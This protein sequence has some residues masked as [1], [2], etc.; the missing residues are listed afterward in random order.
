MAHRLEQADEDMLRA[1]RRGADFGVH[2]VVRVPA[3]RQTD[4]EPAWGRVLRAWPSLTARVVPVDGGHAVYAA[5]APD[6]SALA[7]TEP[8]DSRTILAAD[9]GWLARHRVLPGQGLELLLHHLVVDADSLAAVLADLDAVLAGDAPIGSPDWP[10]AAAAWTPD[11]PRSSEPGRSA[12]VGRA[13]AGSAALP[14]KRR[15]APGTHTRRMLDPTVV[16]RIATAARTAGVTPFAIHWA[17]ASR[18]AAQSD[19]VEAPLAAVVSRRLLTAVPSRA[20]NATAYLAV[21][22][23]P[24]GPGRDGV[25]A[26]FDAFLSVWRGHRPTASPNRSR[27]LVSSANT[28]AAQSYRVIDEVLLG[29]YVVKYPRHLQV[30][31]LDPAGTQVLLEAYAAGGGE[32]LLGQHLRALAELLDELVPIHETQQPDCPTIESPNRLPRNQFPESDTLPTD[33]AVEV[34]T[35]GSTPT[36][37]ASAGVEARGP[38]ERIL[39]ADP[40]TALRDLDIS[41]FDVLD[42]LDGLDRRGVRVGVDSFYSWERVADVLTLLAESVASTPGPVERQSRSA[43]AGDGSVTLAHLSDI[44]IDA[45]RHDEPERYAVGYAY[46]VDPALGLDR[47]DV[48][49][50]CQRVLDRHPALGARLGFDRRGV[51][52]IPGVTRVVVRTV[53]APGLAALRDPQPLS[54]RAPAHLADLAV[55]TVDPVPGDRAP[56]VVALTLHHLLVDHVGL[57]ALVD[58]LARELRG[59]PAW[60]SADWAELAEPLAEARLRALKVW[61][62]DPLPTDLG[63]VGRGGLTP[64]HY[65][66]HRLDWG[67]SD[68]RLVLAEELTRV[69]AAIAEWT[70]QPRGLI[71]SV[72]HGRA[73]PGSDRLVGAL[74]RVLPVAYD[75]AEPA[76]L[77]ASAR[78]VLAGQA[79]CLAD[80]ALPPGGLPVV[81]H[82][83]RGSAAL[84]PGFVRRIEAPSR[85]KFAVLLTLAIGADGQPSTLEVTVDTDRYAAAE[86]ERLCDLLALA[87]AGEL[88]GGLPAIEPLGSRR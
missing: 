84:P 47:A 24:A 23:T 8:L 55:G 73:V 3:D 16:S 31:T 74:A 5:A 57:G 80:L 40:G 67:R 71:G 85:T 78:R 28:P 38:L 42:V 54:V 58:D 83:L 82:A 26:A 53:D 79:A 22:V 49:A 69:C 2:V 19:S 10:W 60:P 9:G 14:A 35:S 46:V 39:A 56:V 6:V 12:A 29:D 62:E 48:A 70:G 75:V 1:E 65:V 51:Q 4:L 32:D 64:G 27:L 41:S 18:Y 36:A 21:D 87:R 17:A 44:F 13:R 30:Q 68:G 33:V 20:G 76:V 63:P 25:R 37:T 15:P 52:L 59:E 7:S 43:A 86:T 50:A 45:V 34:P 77:A 88:T 81:F 11:V 61:R 66:Q 72:H